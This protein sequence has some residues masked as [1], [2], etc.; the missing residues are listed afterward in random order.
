M[1][2]T[3]EMDAAEFLGYQEYLKDQK[4]FTSLQTQLNG[5]MMLICK[6]IKWALE[7]D[8]K[9]PDHVKIIDHEHAEELIEIAE[10]Y[11]NGA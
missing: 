6:K 1:K 7:K 4:R 2:V 8:A 9:R 5:K 11:I 3:V 10:N